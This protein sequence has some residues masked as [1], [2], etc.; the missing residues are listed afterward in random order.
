VLRFVLGVKPGS[1]ILEP[2][3]RVLQAPQI[4]LSRL[5]ALNNLKP[6]YGVSR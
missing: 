5:K 4:N 6:R 2:S 3:G 1:S